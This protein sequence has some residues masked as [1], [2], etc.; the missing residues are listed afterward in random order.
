[1]PSNPRPIAALALSMGIALPATTLLGGAADVRDRPS[2]H[3]GPACDSRFQLDPI[4][5]ALAETARN[6]ARGDVRSANAWVHLAAFQLSLAARERPS[7][8][9]WPASN[10]SQLLDVLASYGRSAYGTD[11]DCDEDYEFLAGWLALIEDLNRS[12]EK[13]SRWGHLAVDYDAI[14]HLVDRI[15]A[16]RIDYDLI[17]RQITA[18]GDSRSPDLPP[19]RSV[20]FLLFGRLAEAKAQP[21]VGAGKARHGRVQVVAQC[22]DGAGAVR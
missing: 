12:P 2:I 1:M 21:Q 13:P 10:A 14:T 19:S 8:P 20:R 7:G 11:P 17:T 22:G 6:Y 4:A 18:I 9:V 3:R 5:D 15:D 16:T